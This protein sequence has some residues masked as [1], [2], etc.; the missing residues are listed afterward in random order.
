[1]TSN[2]PDWI[3]ASWRNAARQEMTRRGQRSFP[4][5]P[6]LSLIILGIVVLIAPRLVIAALASILFL[7]GFVCCYLAWKFIRF[8]RQLTS[9]TR[10]LGGK[11]QIRAYQ[12]KSS[13]DVID[14]EVDDKKIVYH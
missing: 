12:V 13:D 2:R 7:V 8:K 9:F 3:K 10:D 6:G 4:F 5:A 11:I 14:V 1:M